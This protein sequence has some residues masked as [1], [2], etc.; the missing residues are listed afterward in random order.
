M[1]ITRY[2]GFHRLLHAVMA[3][4]IPGLFG[5]GLWM[6]DLDFYHSWY[7]RAPDLHKAVGTIVALLLVPRLLMLL[8]KKPAQP[9][10]LVK[11]A[12]ASMY[13]LLV[14]VLMSGYFIA[15]A[16][17]QGIDVFGLFAVPA[18]PLSIENQADIAGLIHLWSAW[19]LIVLTVLH[20][21]AALKHAWIDKDDTMQRMWGRSISNRELR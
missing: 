20:L 8:V 16:E 14:L 19:A 11:L 13:G 3:L 2:H 6:V 1:Q 21:I 10:L 4:L 17:G 12:H 5:V 15:T 9:Q 18:M 7:H